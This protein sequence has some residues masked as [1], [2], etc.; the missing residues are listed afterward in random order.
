MFNRIG[1]F[2]LTALVSCSVYAADPS[3]LT[4]SGAFTYSSVG[5]GNVNTLTLTLSNAT[6]ETASNIGFVA[7][8]ADTDNLD[9]AVPL[10]VVTS[11]SDGSYSSNDSALTASGYTLAD[12]SSCTFAF[13]MKGVVIDAAA[14]VLD[15]NITE[16]NSDLGAG[17]LAGPFQF[18][19]DP[20]LITA[21][22]SVSEAEL[23]VGSVNHVT[24]QLGNFPPYVST[25][26]SFA[27]G[28]ITFSDG[29]VLASPLNYS[30][31]CG[32]SNTNA[33][34]SNSFT[35]PTASFVT[36]TSCLIEFDVIS[37]SAGV[38]NLLSAAITNAT[39]GVAVGKVSTSFESTIKF[40]TASFSP[41]NLVP[42]SQGM[43]DV[44]LRNTD[45]NYDATNVT[46]TDNLES[47]LSGLALT[48]PLTDV[49]GVGSSVTGTGVISLTGAS[50]TAGESCQFSIP[51]TVPANAT[52]GSYTNEISAIS[53][54]L[55]GTTVN[56]GNSSYAANVFN[57]FSVNS[58][59][60]LVIDT[61][62]GGISVSEV[63]AGDVISVEYSL[64]N[65]DG[66]N[67][68]SSVS[69]THVLS[70]L[71]GF[72]A[73]L[74]ANDFCGAGSTATYNGAFADGPSMAVSGISLSA[75]GTCSFSVDYTVPASFNAGTYLMS[76]GAITATINS[77]VVQSVAPS[78]SQSFSI[79]TAPKLSFVFNP[80][81]VSP[82]ENTTINFEIQNSFGS[83]YD[84]TAVGF[85]MDLDAVLSGITVLSV[86][87]APCGESSAVT[88]AG[89]GA[90]ALANANVAIGE[91]CQFSVS[92]QVPSGASSQHYAF[93]SSALTASLN[94][95]NL[96]SSAA[97]STLQVT[98]F[99]A[100][101]SFSPSSLRV[102]SVATPLTLTYVLNNADPVATVSS[103]AFTESFANINTA[104]T[105]VSTTQADVC[106]VGSSATISGKNL[107]FTGGSLAPTTSCTFDVVLNLPANFMANG[108]SS[109][110]SSVTA[111]VDAT[112]TTFEPMYASF[113]VNTLS[114]VTGVDITSP[115]SDTNIL[116][117]IDFSD[118]VENFD[119]SDISVVNASLNA[120]TP[121]SAKKYTV[122]VTP[123]SD[124]M[125][126]LN[127]AAGVAD[128][129]LD[130]NV[131]N[132]AALEISFEYQTT[133]LVPTPSLSIGTPSSMLVSSTPVSFVIDY[134]D[135][136][137]VNLTASDI[138]VNSTSGA[139]AAT[140]TVQNGD[141]SQPTV[142]LS[143]F[144]GNGTL[145]ISIAANTARYSINLAP[146]AGPSDVFA[147]DTHKPTVTLSSNSTEQITDFTVNI[148]FEENVTGF[149]MGDLT[150]LN[151]SLSNFQA[152]DAKNYSVLVSA[153][154]ETT[155]SID[156]QDSVANDN[157]GNGN[158]VSNT[159]N[160]TYDDLLPSVS[161]SGPSSPVVASFT[162]T[163][164]F[165]ETVTGFD[166]S[167]I[168]ITNANLSNF[169][170]V[171]GKQY[172][173]SVDPIAQA[174]V[175]L[176]I[177]ANVA[178]DG[179]GNGN[180]AADYSVT[181]DFNDAPVISGTPATSV[182]EDSA[183]SFTPTA[184]DE[185]SGDS[186]SFVITN[187]P[188][189]A[190]F[191]SS[192][193]QLSGT[194]T[195]ADVG[196][197]AGIVIGVFDGTV[198][199][200]LSS[201]SITVSN[202]NDA[203]VISGTPAT[204]VNED[205]A[206]SFTPIASDDDSGD[207]LVFSII[208]MPSWASFNSST[209][210]LSGT[211]TNLDVGTT[212]GIII[213]VSDATES[214][215]LAV[216]DIE[217]VNVNDEPV[218]E[219][220]PSLTVEEDSTY[221]FIPTVS[222][223]DEG[224]S[225]S[226][227]IANKPSWASFDTSNG[228]L[229][230]TPTNDD[231]G[232]TKDVM[233]SVT[234]G[235]I[236]IDL[237]MFS[238]EVL[239]VNDAPVFDSEPE[240]EGQAGATYRYLVEVSDVDVGSE[241][242]LS[243]LTGPDWLQL[244]GNSLSGT[245]PMSAAD[246]TFDI[247]LGL[248]DGI[249][250]TL[251]TQEFSLKVVQ[252]TDTEIAVQ[253]YFSPAPAVIN[254]NVNLITEIN[255]VGY[256]AAKGITYE[257]E[258]D[259]QF[260]LS[261]I[262]GFCSEV[263]TGHI[264]CVLNDELAISGQVTSVISFAVV[265]IAAG[266]STAK[267]SLVGDNLNDVT[268]TETASILLANTLAILPGAI[269]S[270]TPADA[271]YAVDINGDSFTDLL[272]YQAA[273]SDIQLLLNDGL[274][275][276]VE[277][278]RV[279]V[280]S[281]LTSLVVADINGDGLS[282]IV[283]TGGASGI[284]KAYMLTA[285]F[286]VASEESLGAIFAD[287]AVV[288][289]VN[290]DGRPEVILAGVYQSQ[291][292]IYSGFGTGA[293]SVQLLPFTLPALTKAKKNLAPMAENV[294]ETG[295]TSLN[296]VQNNSNINIL[297][298][299]QGQTPVLYELNGTVWVGATVQSLTNQSEKIITADLEQDGMLDLFVYDKN[300][301]RLVA[302][303]FDAEFVVSNV[304]LPHVDNILVRDLEADG[305]PEILLLTKTG[306]SIWHYYGINDIRP[307]NAIITGADIAKLELIDLDNDG[308]LDIVVFD[309]QNGLSAWY[310]SANGSIGR[311]D[312]DLA[313]YAQDASFPRINET[314]LVTWTVQNKGNAEATE[315]MLDINVPSD[316]VVTTLPD[317]C[318]LGDGKIRCAIGTLEV[319]QSV[320]IQMWLTPI[321]TG[322]FSL[323][324]M[325]SSFEY[326]VGAANNQNQVNFDV[327]D[328][329]EGGNSGGGLPIWALFTLV[330][331]LFSRF[332]NRR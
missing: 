309:A 91:T 9:F 41:S 271:G 307:D 101:K 177:A 31:D 28:V 86:P 124:G 136:E 232:V 13:D 38:K 157:A 3:G 205:S 162:A 248:T 35:I 32:V 251:V 242:T 55:N 116:M 94:G 90:I 95:V 259:A 291:I 293:T 287:I 330:I 18:T 161:I 2:L 154:G 190:S 170:N 100:S 80:A 112:S 313:L 296:L 331:C 21:S 204:S 256:T 147:V 97:S 16:L 130:A 332:Q 7:T 266:F 277:S 236:Q 311:Q 247:V 64:T 37:N 129:V 102:G 237:P 209:G 26:Y 283:T 22:L 85:N 207:S 303:A 24:L 140:V 30:A 302:N 57:T 306:V 183:Y 240:L 98:Q 262:P 292:A 104:V 78:A 117:T 230:G 221:L 268:T 201:F 223:E 118:D 160:I 151:G 294:L 58:A 167:D 20:T 250:D 285:A 33:S 245:P 5:D 25:F 111:L 327:I 146:A 66:T 214:V 44:T 19:V 137:T 50:V 210:Q 172:T 270:S 188:S 69:F 123:L 312:V 325:V 222:D 220:S 323:S 163:V 6:G 272:V 169:V 316:L 148:L 284:S 61:K 319:A 321:S 34:G 72:T 265:D 253:F 315:V 227:I 219:G 93:S 178:L 92:V 150:I 165:S 105:V 255:N 15:V 144:S 208:N 297:A 299:Y 122:E 14:T 139:S 224:D 110:S 68:A 212:S 244:S 70:N 82:G 233:I 246:Q 132:T 149:E 173:V 174:S 166:I 305:V 175:N 211:P 159:L 273:T 179:L 60:A 156:V 12:S 125:V 29:V 260:S 17:P 267:L 135:A 199:T 225:L 286:E 288:A 238:I 213:S 276:L 103:I 113:L 184:S 62:Q 324:G 269:L 249:V 1:S 289:D 143:D 322:E 193:G 79:I 164:D 231:V 121:V 282:D 10:N 145:G 4:V 239:N 65:V 75:G 298:T 155:V 74:P 23:S 279:P 182:N 241:L 195:N 180:T 142:T 114:V 217:V 203:P 228:T 301:W 206:Y 310:V 87:D 134:N 314:S 52:P 56:A 275:Q 54:D 300:G 254:Q 290:L 77:Q 131:K 73:T 126:T 264:T 84:A 36:T 39:S 27:R 216:F 234:D 158:S 88:G 328:P 107:T 71:F 89:T 76:V 81:V 43:L 252:P 108:Y 176:A 280:T 42:G 46:F 261:S 263:S 329:K 138:A 295:V 191:N 278:S 47:V 109:V 11:C 215:N 127:I 304:S 308:N 63:V 133:P 128:D 51:V 53:Y 194:P 181:Y 257:I 45:R 171:D 48:T 258:Y 83:L 168:Q 218:I 326:D 187:Q 185:D 196:T 96:T 99:S 226:F 281:A 120:F 274:G 189:W 67:A 59:P 243:L 40:V 202:T 141:T 152:L 119:V 229:S 106:G 49:C 197:T 192:T 317:E 320:D 235:T 186:L 115:T 318:V 153:T 200:H 198:T 8:I